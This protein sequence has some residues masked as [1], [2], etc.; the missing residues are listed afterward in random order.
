MAPPLIS[1]QRVYHMVAAMVSRVSAAPS[2]VAIKNR[3]ITIR[4]LPS[5][6]T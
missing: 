1:F 5:A 4:P 3:P 6:N 2:G